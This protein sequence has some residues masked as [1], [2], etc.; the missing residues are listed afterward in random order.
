METTLSLSDPFHDLNAASSAYALAA[1]PARY[2][3]ERQQWAAAANL[4]PR[5][6]ASFHWGDRFAAYEAITHFARALGAA[7]SGNTTAAQSTLR[8]LE[9]LHDVVAQTSAYWANQIEILQLSAR[10]WLA[11]EEGNQLEALR[12]MQLA[13]GLEASTE[14]SP[15]TPGEVLPARELLGDMLLVL[16]RPEEALA[17]Y[18]AALE[19]SPNRF[20][21]LYGAGRAAELE[22]DKGKAAFYYKK[23]VEM[24]ANGAE[25]KRLQQARAFLA[26][27]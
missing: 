14:K 17:E 7:R 10:A 27:N 18:E 12:L 25:R 24:T 16:E 2:T 21:S 20:N 9:T 22:G 6:P 15:T 26:E 8:E 23:L 19:R 1:I 13:A 4:K 5:E 3:L 11:L